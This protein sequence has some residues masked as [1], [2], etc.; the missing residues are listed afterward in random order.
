MKKY[1]WTLSV[2]ALFAIG[3]AASDE[4]ESSSSGSQMEQKQETEAERQAREQKEK[5]SQQEKKKKEAAEAGYERGFSYGF[6]GEDERFILHKG[7][8]YYNARYGAPTDNE[9]MEL[10]K[11]YEENLYKGYEEGK[12]AR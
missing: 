5:E 4:D 1:F 9:K 6:S 10:F 2:M 12:K 11:I 8:A 7:K 3:F